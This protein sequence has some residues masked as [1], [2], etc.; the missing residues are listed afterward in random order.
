VRNVDDR[1]NR[2]LD[3]LLLTR[4]LAEHPAGENLLERAVD[5]PRGEHRLAVGPHLAALLRRLDH[6]PEREEHRLDLVEPLPDS[7][8]ASDLAHE[9]ADRVRRDEPRAEIDAREAAK[10]LA[11]RRPGFLD[12]L[13]VED[14]APP[15]LAE[16]RLEHFVLRAEVVVEKPVRNAR[17]LCDVAHTGC[18]ESLPREDARSSVEQRTASVF[19]PVDHGHGA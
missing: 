9:H 1:C 3:V 16:E 17:L 13:R 11:Q 6:P 5:D 8:A 19:A 12:P 2:A 4:Q 14:E 10:L 7:G 18:V 15:R